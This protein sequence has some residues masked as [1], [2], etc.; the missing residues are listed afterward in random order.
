LQGSNAGSNTI[1]GII[2]D[3]SSSNTTAVTKAGAGTWLLS[4]VN[5]YTG[6][7]TINAGKLQ[8]GNANTSSGGALGKTTSASVTFGAGSTGQLQ[9]NGNATTIIGLNTNAT[10]GTP[11][12]E[13]GSSTVA[14]VLTVNTANTDTYAGLL[15]DG[16]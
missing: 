9:L 1:S 4:G 5:T 2:V 3:N 12:I 7:T 11:I 14:A 6:G 13:N 16:S 10:V 15:Q 8:L